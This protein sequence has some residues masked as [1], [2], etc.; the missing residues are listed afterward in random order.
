MF[1]SLTC[2]E[3]GGHGTLCVPLPTLQDAI[4]LLHLAGVHINL[5]AH[6]AEFFRHRRT[7]A[8]AAS[9]ATA[10]SR[11]LM[12]SA[13]PDWHFVPF[14]AV[15]PVSPDGCSCQET[16]RTVPRAFHEALSAPPASAPPRSVL[17]PAF[18]SFPLP[19]IEEN[20]P[21]FLTFRKIPHVDDRFVD[22]FE[23]AGALAKAPSDG[24]F[25]NAMAARC[26]AFAHAGKGIGNR[27]EAEVNERHAVA[28]LPPQRNLSSIA[29]TG[30]CR[31]ER[32]LRTRPD[33]LVDAI[34]HE[35]RRADVGEAAGLMH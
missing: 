7:P 10:L 4:G 9:F 30:E 11:L 25:G 23:I 32:E 21:T 29:Q 31:L 1:A 33:Q 28:K 8:S 16:G 18:P 6:R 24:L 17:R 20:E 13:A 5:L 3:A 26:H 15:H 35:A 22:R 19:R 27:G 12:L 2:G 34:E 14:C